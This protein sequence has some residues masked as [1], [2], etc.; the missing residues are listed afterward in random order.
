V[1]QRI[2]SV[3][4]GDWA[5]RTSNNGGETSRAPGDK[6]GGSAPPH[7]SPRGQDDRHGSGLGR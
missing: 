4:P 6:R 7:P 1:T 2:A 5:Y 3:M